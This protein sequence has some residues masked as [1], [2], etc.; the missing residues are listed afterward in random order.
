MCTARNAA[1][2]SDGCMMKQHLEL[3]KD[4]GF[5]VCN[6]APLQRLKPFLIWKTR[7][8]VEQNFLCDPLLSN[9]R[10]LG[11]RQMPLF[12]VFLSH[13]FFT[14]SPRSRPS[15]KLLNERSSTSALNIFTQTFVYIFYIPSYDSFPQPV[16]GCWIKLL[17]DA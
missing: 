15:F 7:L 2:K 13:C 11:F 9:R 4:S 16:L 14:A 6:V 10:P 17:K 3:N 1:E 8:Q 12:F 5:Y